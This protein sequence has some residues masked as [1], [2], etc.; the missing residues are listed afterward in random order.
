[1]TKR[2]TAPLYDVEFQGALGGRDVA[3]ARWE[4]GIM[5][6]A[7]RKSNLRDVVNMDDS[8]AQ[9]GN[10]SGGPFQFIAST[11]NAYRGRGT[12]GN[13]RGTLGQA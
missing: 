9:T 10:P 11:Y 6:V 2:S 3:R 8:N 5:L 13:Y 4:A 1:M 7:R 12:S